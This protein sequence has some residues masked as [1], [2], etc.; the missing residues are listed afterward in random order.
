MFV[1]RLGDDV[2][3]AG[4]HAGYECSSHRLEP[5]GI[6]AS[7]LGFDAGVVGSVDLEQG[8]DEERGSLPIGME[9]SLDGLG[10]HA[11]SLAYE[12]VDGRAEH[13]PAMVGG[14][15]V[16]DE[17]LENCVPKVRGAQPGDI[18]ILLQRFHAD[19]YPIEQDARCVGIT[20]S[21]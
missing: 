2:G 10:E 4:A 12:E 8:A 20:W 11:D 7:H 19:L 17:C 13:Q 9:L 3:G 5:R 15:R 6:T 16:G 21:G 18:S 14:N 1:R